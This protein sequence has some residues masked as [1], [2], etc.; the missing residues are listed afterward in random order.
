MTKLLFS[1]VIMAAALVAFTG[2]KKDET[3]GAA[4]G[5][6]TNVD[7][8]AA[9]REFNAAEPTVRAEYDKAALAIRHGNYGGALEQLGRLAS[10]AKLTPEQ[11]K[12]VKDLMAQVQQALT[13][14]A[15]K[16]IDDV[17]KGLPK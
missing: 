14:G 17:K 16:A 1:V 11:Q 3:P 5:A 6:V 13:K 2:C 9:E 7:T 15:N 8:A 10:N 12:A 4:G